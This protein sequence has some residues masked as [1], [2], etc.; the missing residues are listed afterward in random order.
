[1]SP[2]RRLRSFGLIFGS[3]LLGLWLLGLLVAI[4]GVFFLVRS[5]PQLKGEATIEGLTAEATAARDH[6]GVPRIEAA[7][8]RDAA[9]ALGWLHGQERFFQMDLLRRSA[10]GQLSALAGEATLS[11]DRA[12]IVHRFEAR[13]RE[14]FVQLSGSEKALLEA[15]TEGVNRGLEALAMRPFEYL[16]LRQDPV[17]WHPEDCLL[18][19][20]ALYLDLQSSGEGRDDFTRGIAHR[21]LPPEVYQF[22]FENGSQWEGTMTGLPGERPPRP[23]LPVPPSEAFAYLQ[24]AERIAS[25]DSVPSQRMGE[26]LSPS[27]HR[28]RSEGVPGSNAWV[29][30]PELGGG[31]PIL[32]NDQHLGLAVP[33]VWYHVSLAYTAD[34]G[35]LRE[36][37]GINLPGTPLIVSGSNG[38]LVWGATVSYV[39]TLDLVEIV[40]SDETTGFYYPGQ[41]QEPIRVERFEEE[42]AIAGKRVGEIVSWNESV[43]GPLI[44]RDEV[45]RSYATQWVAY[46]PGAVNLQLLPLSE[47]RTICEALPHAHAAGMPV[48]NLLMADAEGNIGWTLAGTLPDRPQVAPLRPVDALAQEVAWRGR[49]SAEDYPRLLNPQGGRIWSANNRLVRTPEHEALGEGGFSRDGRAVRLAELMSGEIPATL[50]GHAGWQLDLRTPRMDAWHDLLLELLAHPEWDDLPHRELIEEALAQWPGEA[51]IGSRG[52][53]LI[54]RFRWSTRERVYRRI[55]APCLAEDGRFSIYTIEGDGPL[56]ALLKAKPEAAIDPVFGSWESELRDIFEEVLAHLREEGQSELP[57]WGERNQLRMRH[58]LSRAIPASGWLLDMPNSQ[59]DG[60]SFALRV[61]RPAFAA[62]MRLVASPGREGG[63]LTLPAGNSGH[64]LSSAYRATQIHWVKG[65]ALPLS[66][67]APVNTLRLT[68]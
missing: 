30:G 67:G 42:L 63:I 23:I 36:V 55:F 20:F 27:W 43:W 61:Q 29:V 58:P 57:T 37:T 49:L 68:P 10:S 38:D 12:R 4:V 60:D 44:I 46:L 21:K 59:L 32:A 39:D 35:D 2:K 19:G 53:G 47:A 22:F 45:G 6:R 51:V 18:V 16:V 25:W 62:S 28:D 15:Y 41:E 34:D 54:R 5:L 31:A 26:S 50:E 33:N 64:P 14:A 24:E 3:F 13:A 65:E 11:L 7:N 48:L 1:M 8:L 66:P 17:P 40:W 52:H 56:L 9:R